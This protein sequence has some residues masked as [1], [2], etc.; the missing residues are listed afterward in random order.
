MKKTQ[1]MQEKGI[2]YRRYTIFLFVYIFNVFLYC[3]KLEFRPVYI[4]ESLEMRIVRNDV[5]GIPADGTVDK[6]IVI[7]VCLN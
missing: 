7:G 1:K 4:V 2:L 6:L 5:F 3:N